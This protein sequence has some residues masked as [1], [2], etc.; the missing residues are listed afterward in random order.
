MK[1]RYRDASFAIDS[2]NLAALQGLIDA[3]EMARQDNADLHQQ[4]LFTNEL[5]NTESLLDL[6]TTRTT[7]LYDMLTTSLLAKVNSSLAA[8]QV[9]SLAQSAYRHTPKYAYRAYIRTHTT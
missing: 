5:V 6:Q 9:T 3:A 7:A 2:V 1:I 8:A 4:T